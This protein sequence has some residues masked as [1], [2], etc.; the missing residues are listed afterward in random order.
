TYEFSPKETF[1]KRSS[2]F[3]CAILQFQGTTAKPELL[4][5][6]L[7]FHVRK[8]SNRRRWHSG[9]VGVESVQV[10]EEG[11]TIWFTLLLVK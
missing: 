7:G 9:E 3:A 8:T 5:R 1:S 11:F 6:G 4:S 10:Q 2:S